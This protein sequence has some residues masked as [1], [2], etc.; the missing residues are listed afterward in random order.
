MRWLIALFLFSAPLAA[1]PE[2]YDMVVDP[3][4]I[5]FSYVFDEREIGG[6]FPSYSGNIVLDLDNVPNSKVDVT[7]ATGDGTAGFIF[8]TQTLRGPKVLWSQKYPT[9]RFVST[10]ARRD[11]MSAILEGELTI[12][13]VTQ[14]V[15]LDVTLF[16]DAGT[17]PGER[18]ELTFFATTEINRSDFGANGFPNLVSDELKIEIKARILRQK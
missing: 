12:R 9:M 14:P 10:S 2:P 17:E 8:A 13:D 15:T 18:D 4:A 16:R 3:D 5:T 1:A 11:G 7:I 6:R